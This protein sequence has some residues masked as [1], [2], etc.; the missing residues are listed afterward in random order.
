MFIDT[1][2]EQDEPARFI[3]RKLYRWFVYYEIDEA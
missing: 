2:F 3:C 1:I